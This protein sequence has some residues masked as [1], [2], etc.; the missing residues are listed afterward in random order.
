MCS[1]PRPIRD[2]KGR[3][4]AILGGRPD[5]KESTGVPFMADVGA[6]HDLFQAM[7]SA[8]PELSRRGGED[9]GCHRRGSHAYVNFGVTMGPGQKVRLSRLSMF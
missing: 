1:T 7:L 4:I 2:A 9:G 6:V 5:C 8:H 3:C